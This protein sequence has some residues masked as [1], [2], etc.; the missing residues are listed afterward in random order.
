[1]YAFFIDIDGT[2]FNGKSVSDKVIDTFE[3]ARKAGHKVF[4][5]TARAYIGMPE[6]VYTLPVDGFVNSHGLEIYT[7][8]K[9]IHRYFIPQEQL[10][11]IAEYCFD[12]DIN[13]YFEGEVR[14]DIN[15]DDSSGL[16]PKN[17][18]QFKGMLGEKRIS[19]FIFYKLPSDKEKNRFSKDFNILGLEGVLKGYSKSYGIKIVE[20]YYGIPSENTVAIGDTNQDIDMVTYAG[21]G[22]SMGNGSNDLKECAKYITK[23][24][25]E[26]GAAFAIDCLLND[27]FSKLEKE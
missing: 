24:C 27:D 14:I 17:I 25:A 4:I 11:E 20:D 1:M 21:I 13:M 26:D 10:H 6:Q 5:N 12:N 22:I 3:R 18:E 16:Y 19:K 8:N 7:D 2:I 9:F 15:K 23:T